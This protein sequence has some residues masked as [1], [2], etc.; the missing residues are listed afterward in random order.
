M[1]K[2]TDIDVGTNTTY[3]FQP[4]KSCMFLTFMSETWAS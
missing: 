2:G 4:S 1:L 3:E